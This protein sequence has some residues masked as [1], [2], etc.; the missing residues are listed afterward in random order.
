MKDCVLVLDTIRS[1]HNTGSMF[2]TADGAGVSR[3]ILTG[4]TPA[5][6]DTSGHARKDIAKVALGAEVAIPWTQMESPMEAAKQLKQEGYTILAL[7]KTPG[8]TSLFAYEAPEKFALFV[9]NE[10]EGIPEEVLQ[11][12][13]AVLEIPM[14][15]MK[16]SLNVSFAA[17]VA[18]YHLCKV[19]GNSGN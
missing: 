16:E 4:Y 1:A 5:P 7:E 15:G 13:D 10:V 3:I 19:K 11:A 18:L 6:I 8:A 2:R 12:S 9:G 14:G 17:G